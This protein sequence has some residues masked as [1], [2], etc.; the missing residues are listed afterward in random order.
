MLLTFFCR[1]CIWLDDR[2]SFH[3]KLI[4]TS[5]LW[6]RPTPTKE[7]RPW[8]CSAPCC[9]RPFQQQKSNRGREMFPINR[10]VSTL[11]K[12]E[13]NQEMMAWIMVLYRV[14]EEETT[15]LCVERVKKTT[16]KIYISFSCVMSFAPGAG[17]VRRCFSVR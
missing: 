12:T 16:R 3:L 1:L 5:V 7:M 15:I 10:N 14:Q 13:P 4:D 9:G 17:F 6:S 11:V 8:I 2:Q